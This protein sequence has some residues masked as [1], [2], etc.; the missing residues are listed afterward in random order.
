MAGSYLAHLLMSGIMLAAA[1]AADPGRHS[2]LVLASMR[3]IPVIEHDAKTE[4][5]M[6]YVIDVVSDHIRAPRPS[7]DLEVML[8][9]MHGLFDLIRQFD[10][11]NVQK[12]FYTRATRGACRSAPA[13]SQCTPVTMYK[14]MIVSVI[15][16]RVIFQHDMDHI[17]ELIDSAVEMLRAIEVFEWRYN[18]AAA[19]AHAGILH[20]YNAMLGL[21]V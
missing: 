18:T 13:W 21:P 15:S 17:V 6:R 20:A 16:D 12:V 14:E 3:R 11:E 5:Y 2:N 10:K 9:E 19:G 7:V 8:D 1:S 4:S